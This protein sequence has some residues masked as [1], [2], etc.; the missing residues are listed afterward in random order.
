MKNLLSLLCASLF[1]VAA[2]AQNADNGAVPAVVLNA[3]QKQCPNATGVKWEQGGG[4]YQPVFRKNGAL[5]RL[6]FDAG[7]RYLHTS[8]QV[9]PAQLPASATAYVNGKSIDDT[10]LLTLANGAKRYEVISG[11]NDYLFDSNGRFLKI[12]SGPNKE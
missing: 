5:T 8:V 10:E 2:F 3:F 4:Y 1:A 9:T 7:G 12:A 11:G 6:L